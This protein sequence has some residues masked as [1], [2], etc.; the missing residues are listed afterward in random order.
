MSVMQDTTRESIRALFTL[1]A[2]LGTLILIMIPPVD[3][4]SDSVRA[5]DVVDVSHPAGV[6][7]IERDAKRSPTPFSP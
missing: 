3:A 7:R 2:V 5:S 4:A 6:E 1:A